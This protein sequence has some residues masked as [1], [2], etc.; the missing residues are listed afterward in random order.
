VN[1][2]KCKAAEEKSIL[3]EQN[4]HHSANPDI[5][6]ALLNMLHEQGLLTDKVLSVAVNKITKAIW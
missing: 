4:Y 6:I 5:Q 2:E 3:K 1:E